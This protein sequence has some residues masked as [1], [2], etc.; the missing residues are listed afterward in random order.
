MD[1]VTATAMI[2]VDYTLNLSIFGELNAR[3]FTLQRLRA[4]VEKIVNNAYPGSYPQ[5][6]LLQTGTLTV[7]VAGEV[8]STYQPSAWGLTRLSSV[9]T[10]HTTPYSSN[11]DIEITP[12]RGSAKVYDLFKAQRLGDLSQD[13][14]LK[15]GDTV[16]VSRIERRLTISG[17]VERPGAYQL[18]KGETLRELIEYYENGF[19]KLSDPAAI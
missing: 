8:T 16:T 7:T 11:R 1:T 13:P 15:P 5:L 2:E 18:L 12:R 3:G 19:T 9:L 17:E 4:E 6:K 14:Y 10:G